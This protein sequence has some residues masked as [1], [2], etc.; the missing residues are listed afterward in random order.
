M[1]TVVTKHTSSDTVAAGPAAMTTEVRRDIS[2]PKSFSTPLFSS[3]MIC[4][5]EHILLDYHNP[6][7]YLFELLSELA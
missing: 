1:D 4:K 2:R 6:L 3:T 7:S 5:R